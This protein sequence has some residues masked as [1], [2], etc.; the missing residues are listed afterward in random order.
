MRLLKVFMSLITLTI[1]LATAA[2][3][4]ASTIRDTEIE[5]TLRYYARPIFEAAGLDINTV[6]IHLIND[7]RLNAFVSGG[8]HMFFNTGLLM[9]ADNADQVI[10]VMAHETGHITGGHLS[11]FDEGIRNAQARSIATLL[12]SIPLAI[13]TGKGEFVVAGQS[14]SQQIGN[15]SFLKFTRSMEQAADQAAV[16]FLDDAGISA[17]GMLEFFGKLQ[18]NE[19][20]YSASQNPY[21]RSHPLT[22]DRIAFV[23]HHVQISRFSENKLDPLYNELHQRMKAK[24]IGYFMAD[25]VDRYYDPSDTGFYAQYARVFSLMQRHKTEEAIQ[26]VDGLINKLPDDPYFQEVKGDILFRAG[27]I[28]ESIPF[29]ERAVQILEWADQIRVSA[30]R[31][32][33]EASNRSVSDSETEKHLKAAITHLDAAQ[34]YAPTSAFSWQLKGTAYY[35]LGNQPKAKLAEAEYAILTRNHEKAKFKAREAM[36]L[37]PK[38][39]PDWLRA[40]DIE[41]EA[42]KGEINDVDENK[43]AG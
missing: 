6:R 26:I 39:S 32:H 22:A 7:P 38:G 34:R 23:D 8:Q 16:G 20:L 9:A 12:L 25:S 19:A 29:F 17:E 41:F 10:G 43:S 13:A 1:G 4:Q 15:R 30:A 2:S 27:R 33:I 14:A 3:A 36:E 11:Q 24:L 40:Q 37:L 28:E 35:R 18:K 31:A 5:N 42:N 21:T